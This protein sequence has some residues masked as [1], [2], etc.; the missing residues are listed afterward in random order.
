[1]E[2][3]N[4]SEKEYFKWYWSDRHEHCKKC[5]KNCKQSWK[6]IQIICRNFDKIEEV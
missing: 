3:E 6:V 4:M 2:I 5:K 1:M